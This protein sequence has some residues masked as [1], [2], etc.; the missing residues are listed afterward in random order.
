M[1]TRLFVKVF[2]TYGLCGLRGKALAA[3]LLLAVTFVG[4]TARPVYA[5]DPVTVLALGDSL[6]QEYGL[7]QADG[8]VPQ[9]G[10]WLTQQGTA[11]RLINGGVSGDT[12]QGGAARAAWSLTDDVDA[13][14]VA[15]GGNDLLRGIDPTVSRANLETILKVAEQKGV[16][17]L[18]IGLRAPRNYGPEYKTAFDAIY[19]ELAETHDALY[20]ESFFAGIEAQGGGAQQKYFQADG[21]H[22]NKAGVALIVEGIGP[23][24]VAL[25]ERAGQK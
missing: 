8:F 12:T 19:P 6:T 24:V 16:P 5:E 13:M 22:P 3:F 18:L 20:L 1:R 17:V 11:A 15:L 2:L 25:I 7:V 23:S 14:I 10:Q 9:L 4:P 21:I